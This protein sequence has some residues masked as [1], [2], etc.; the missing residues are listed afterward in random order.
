MTEVTVGFVGVVVT[1]TTAE[2]SLVGSATLVAVTV[3]V[4]GLAGAVKTPEGLM[5]PSEA[6]QVTDLLEVPRTV[7]V[8]GRVP[9]MSDVEEAGEIVTE[10]PKVVLL[11]LVGDFPTALPAHPGIQATVATRVTKSSRSF[12]CRWSSK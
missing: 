8:K 3:A 12:G 1:V 9:L 11:G 4:P 5:V 7:A 6:F 2:A 10:I